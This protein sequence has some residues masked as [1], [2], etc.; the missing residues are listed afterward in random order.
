MVT[1][2]KVAEKVDVEVAR[3]YSYYEACEHVALM[4]DIRK[5]DVQ[6]AAVALNLNDYWKFW[7]PRMRRVKSNEHIFNLSKEEGV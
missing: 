1:A 2:E 3:G 4:F 5:E 7:G 6:I